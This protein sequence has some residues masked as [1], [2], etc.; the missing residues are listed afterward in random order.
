MVTDRYLYQVGW[1]AEDDC[2]VAHCAELPSI[3]GHGE[4]QER[5][6]SEAETAARLAVEWMEQEK[7]TIPQP[8]GNREFSGTLS[9]RIPPESHRQVAVNAAIQGV[10]INQFLTS[11]IERNVSGDQNLLQ[12]ESLQL[13]VNRLTK[14]VNELESRSS[15]PL[16][17]G[18]PERT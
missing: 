5:A 6:L 16:F 14:L 13:L 2:Y 10:S 7:E 17:T 4:T 3:S 8:F 12:A 9:L 1:S 18:L 11:L 15:H